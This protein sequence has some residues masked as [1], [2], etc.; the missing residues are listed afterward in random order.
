[1]ALG[2]ILVVAV[3]MLAATTLLPALI[4]LL[5]SAPTRAP[6]VH[7]AALALRSR[8]AGAGRRAD[9]RAPASGSAGPRASC[10]ARCSP[11]SASAASCSRSRSPRSSS[12]TGNGALRQFPEGHET[13]VGLRGGRDADRPG[14][15]RRRCRSS[16]R[17]ATA[18]PRPASASRALDADRGIARGRRTPIPSRDGRAVLAHRDCRAHDGES[19]AAKAIVDAA[20]RRA[21]RRRR[22]RARG[23]RRRHDRVAVATSTTSS[24]GSMWKI[25]LF[26]LGLSYLVLLVLLRS[27][28]LPLKAVLMNLLSVGAAYGVLVAVFQWGWFDGFLG[29]ESPATSTRSRRRSCSRSCSA[30][31]WTTRCSCS[32]RIRERYEAT[33]DTRRAVAEGLAASARTIT[34]RR[35]DH[36]RRVRGVRR[37]RRAVDQAARPRHARSRSRST[38]RS[39]GSCSCPRRWS[40]WAAGTGGCRGRSRGCCRVRTSRRRRADVRRRTAAAAPA[41]ARRAARAQP[42]GEQARRGRPARDHVDEVVERTLLASRRRSG[43]RPRSACSPLS[44]ARYHGSASV[45]SHCTVSGAGRS[46]ARVEPR[47][48]AVEEDLHASGSR[49]GPSRC[50]GARPAAA[51]CHARRARAAA[52]PRAADGPGSVSIGSPIARSFA[53]DEAAPSLEDLSSVMPKHSCSAGPIPAARAPRRYGSVLADHFDDRVRARRGPR[54]RGRRAASRRRRCGAARRAR[55]CASQRGS[56]AACR[57]W[58]GSRSM[59]CWPGWASVASTTTW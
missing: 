5:G 59:M 26:V 45:K 2:A 46:V 54:R 31:R 38:R 30:S 7:V 40:C 43:C 22:R 50:R 53:P 12:T 3:S 10:A 35:A 56:R 25:L 33:G 37:H 57:A 6:A 19:A 58:S 48:D 41:A 1:M 24:R 23:R 11:W 42:A 14:R 13:R 9:A 52:G 29:F 21:A 32:A 28:V 15:D 8:G 27:V 34:T 4:A 16:R 49:A 55:R 17:A 47:R 39:C 51:S 36:G 18:R 20:A 44:S